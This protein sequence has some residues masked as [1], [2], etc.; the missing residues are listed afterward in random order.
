[1][2]HAREMA[3]LHESYA[4]TIITLAN[5]AVVTGEPINRPIWWIAP[6]DEQAHA[7]DS[8]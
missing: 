3:E 4:S 5:D 2:T 1:M 6:D 8:G 7:I